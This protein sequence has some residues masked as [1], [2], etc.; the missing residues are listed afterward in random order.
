M[1]GVTKDTAAPVVGASL[2]GTAGAGRLVHQPGPG[3]DRR[4]RRRRR[5]AGRRGAGR[6]RLV[7]VRRSG[8]GGR[9]RR[10]DRDLPGGRR[11]RQRLGARLGRGEGRPDGTGDDVRG[12]SRR[13]AP[14]PRPRCACPPPTPPA[15]SPRRWC[16]STTGSGSRSP[17][18]SPCRAAVRTP[19]RGSPSTSPATPRRCR[20][21]QVA[22]LP[23]DGRPA[24]RRA[25]AAAGQRDRRDRPQAACHRRLLERRTS[26][27]ATSGCGTGS[28]SPVRRRR[29]TAL[30]E[31]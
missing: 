21:V 4:A 15:A 11:V 1:P 29:P 31:A 9:R 26:P 18:P 7:A 28:R 20:H 6:H 22:A 5:A 17:A 3:R 12:R 24:A 8:R 27:S 10:A 16:R 13:R 19:S 25:G 23:T 2:R 30:V 14:R